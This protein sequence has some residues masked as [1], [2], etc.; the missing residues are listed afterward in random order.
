MLRALKLPKAE[1]KMEL[2]NI[3]RDALESRGV[4]VEE[5]DSYIDY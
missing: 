1:V 2:Q 4:N 5:R 3:L